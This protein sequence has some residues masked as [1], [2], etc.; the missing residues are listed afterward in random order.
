MKSEKYHTYFVTLYYTQYG[1]VF[2]R[3]VSGYFRAPTGAH[4][5]DSA[6]FYF[7]APSAPALIQAVEEA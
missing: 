2:G 7:F 6:R 1:E 3:T 4:A 5:A